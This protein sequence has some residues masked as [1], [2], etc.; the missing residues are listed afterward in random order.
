MFATYDG[1][2]LESGL[3]I[4]IN[5]VRVDDTSDSTGTYSGLSRTTTPFSFGTDWNNYPN[6]GNKLSG[7]YGLGQVYRRELSV[8]EIQQ[9]FNATRGRY[10]V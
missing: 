2:K 4:Y 8:A 10:G 5:G 6:Q 1:S 3:K 9:N 7:Y